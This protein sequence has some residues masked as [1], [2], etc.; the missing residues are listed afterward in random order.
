MRGEI[1][2]DRGVFLAAEDLL[3]PKLRSWNANV[4]KQELG[5]E[6]RE[7]L[8]SEYP[9]DL[10]HRLPGAHVERRPLVVVLGLDVEDRIARLIDG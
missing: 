3:A 9:G 10:F 5:N 1:Y 6:S 7:S 8:A 4:P 2:S